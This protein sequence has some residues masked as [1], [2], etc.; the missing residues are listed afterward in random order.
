[1]TSHS[2][3]ADPPDNQEIMASLPKA[4]DIRDSLDRPLLPALINK[5]DGR[6]YLA[7]YLAITQANRIFGHGGWY[8]E[9]KHHAAVTNNEGYVIG[10]KC[11]ARVTVPALGISVEGVGFE[12]MTKRRDARQPNQDAQAHDTAMKGAESDAVKRALRYLGDQF[13]NSLYEKTHER[14]KM[15]D[16][17]EKM[18][19]IVEASV[20]SATKKLMG[21]FRSEDD[22]PI[23]SSLKHYFS[24]AESVRERSNTRGTTEEP[25]DE[26]D[27][28]PDVN[29][30][31][32]PNG[33]ADEENHD[34]MPP[35]RSRR[36]LFRSS[37]SNGDDSGSGQ[38][39]DDPDPDTDDDRDRDWDSDRD[40][41]NSRSN[42]RNSSRE[43]TGRPGDSDHADPDDDN[44]PP[45]R[46]RR[47][48]PD[49]YPEDDRDRRGGDRDRERD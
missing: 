24:A 23:S 6:E 29:D 25:T 26:T 9:I 41:D 44:D 28:F 45:S 3:T 2:Q 18:M 48:D 16:Y 22:V 14:R 10:Y 13:G 36:D 7:I 32:E 15:F 47:E 12:Q 5:K 19:G 17:A 37:P 43:R 35:R 38:P 21:P 1:M 49:D 11:V 4:P 40:R 27:H 31:E 42:S 34:D 8:P 30:T 46:R 39:D 20:S 33:S